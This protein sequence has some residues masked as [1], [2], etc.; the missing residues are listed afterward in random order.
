M[1]CW[2]SLRSPDRFLSLVRLNALF[3]LTSLVCHAPLAPANRF[4]ALNATELALGNEPSLAA[5]RA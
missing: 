1:S 2:I 3:L 5:D 4:L